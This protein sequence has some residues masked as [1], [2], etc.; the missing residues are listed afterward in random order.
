[1]GGLKRSPTKKTKKSFVVDRVVFLATP[2]SERW[3]LWGERK[4][5]FEECIWV[6]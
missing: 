6:P 4:S 5:L 1:L 3:F 2:G